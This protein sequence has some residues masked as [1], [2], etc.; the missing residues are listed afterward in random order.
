MDEETYPILD[1]IELPPVKAVAAR[2]KKSN[3]EGVSLETNKDNTRFDNISD[4]LWELVSTP[5]LVKG[6]DPAVHAKIHAQVVKV[7]QPGRMCG[8]RCWSPTSPITLGATA[9]SALYGDDH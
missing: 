7:V 4:S 3:S 9:L 8:T 1:D 6:E 5:S 2:S